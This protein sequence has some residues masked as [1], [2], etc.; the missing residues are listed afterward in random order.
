VAVAVKL[1]TSVDIVDVEGVPYADADG[2]VNEEVIDDEEFAD[3]LSQSPKPERH[4][5]PQKSGPDPQY[6]Y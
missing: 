3:E 2:R 4:P 6:W 1:L 5:S